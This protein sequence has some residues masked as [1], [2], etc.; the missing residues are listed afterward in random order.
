MVLRAGLARWVR[1]TTRVD[2]SGRLGWRVEGVMDGAACWATA[3]RVQVRDCCR[4]LGSA[5]R[6]RVDGMDGVALCIPPAASSPRQQERGAMRAFDGDTRVEMYEL[7]S[8]A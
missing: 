7:L 2:D 5:T 1:L 6:L 3:V 4:L 8:G